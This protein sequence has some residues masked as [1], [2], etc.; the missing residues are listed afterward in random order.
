MYLAGLWD[1][2]GTNVVAA[3]NQL[4]I[5]DIDPTSPGPE[6]VFAGFDGQIHAVSATNTELWSYTYTTDPDVLTG[7]VVIGDLSGDGRPEIVF[8]SYT[9]DEGKGALFILD[10]GG[11]LQQ[12]VP[13]PHR[14]AMPVPTLAD[15]DGDG[16]VEIVISLKDADDKVESADVYTVPGSATNCLPWPTGRGNYLRNGVAK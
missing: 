6:I 12:T 4:S 5:A 8:A 3:T 14:G 13:L 11:N 7:G 15:V 1:Y 10:A 9:I 2:D 16:T